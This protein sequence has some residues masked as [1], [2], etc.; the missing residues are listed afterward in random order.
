MYR[1]VSEKKKQLKVES[2]CNDLI[3]F[4]FYWVCFF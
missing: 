1:K 2:G 4:T 3:T